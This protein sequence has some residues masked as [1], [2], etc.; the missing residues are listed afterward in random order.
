MISADFLR[1]TTY[2][3]GSWGLLHIIAASC[4]DCDVCAY[5][6]MLGISV[7]RRC[8]EI[9]IPGEQASFR[10][11]GLHGTYFVLVL[12][13]L[14]LSSVSPRLLWAIQSTIKKLGSCKLIR[15]PIVLPA[16]EWN[17]CG[18]AIPGIAHCMVLASHPSLM[19]HNRVK[20]QIYADQAQT[21]SLRPAQGWE[22][23][24]LP[25]LS[26]CVRAEIARHGVHSHI[27]LAS[28]ECSIWKCRQRLEFGQ[29]SRSKPAATQNELRQE[30]QT[31]SR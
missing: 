23:F 7:C 1:E 14:S 13:T 16:M 17:V 30:V 3:P 8:C 12:Y 2:F 28:S 4:D 20:F 25:T 10:T 6:S 19:R 9:N 24:L 5:F 15:D 27:S 18:Q 26:G 29:H 21:G 22:C 11:S 31:A